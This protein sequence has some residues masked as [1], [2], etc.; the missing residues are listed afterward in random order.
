MAAPSG[1]YHLHHSCTGASKTVQ[2]QRTS[3]LLGRKHSGKPS[4]K[5]QNTDPL[6]EAEDTQPHIRSEGQVLAAALAQPMGCS[7]SPCL[8]GSGQWGALAGRHSR[9]M[10]NAALADK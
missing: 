10:G 9:R 8:L 5:P 7:S 6:L 4:R 2:W 1:W 3:T